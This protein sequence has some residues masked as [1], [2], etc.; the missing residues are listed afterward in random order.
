MDQDH[1]DDVTITMG[2]NSN[3]SS[4]SDRE[5]VHLLPC[6]VKHNGDA[7][8]RDYFSRRI[9][10][11]KDE[12]TS[13]VSRFR[14]RKMKCSGKIELPEGVDGLVLEYARNEDDWKVQNTFSSI[15]SWGHDAIPSKNVMNH[16][17][18][19]FALSRALH[20]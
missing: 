6:Q 12:D 10:K 7:N 3:S 19:W 20:G 17:S 18:D 16:A 2:N 14:G 4:S 13:K 1:Y 15:Y 5:V 11:V 8:V 9:Q